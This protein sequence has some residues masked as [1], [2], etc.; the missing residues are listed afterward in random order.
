MLICGKYSHY[1][2]IYPTDMSRLPDTYKEMYNYF[3][4]GSSLYAQVV[5]V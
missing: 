1:L 4:S 2:S 3:V 5:N